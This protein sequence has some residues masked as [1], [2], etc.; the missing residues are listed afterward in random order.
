MPNN[1][2]LSFV[3]PTYGR[4]SLEEACRSIFDY[5][6]ED[7]KA[8]YSIIIG[9]DSEGYGEVDFVTALIVHRI[10]RGGRC[11]I[12]RTKV[13]NI[14][15]LKQKIYQEA[16]LSLTITQTVVDQ[17]KQFIS[18]DVL[19]KGLEIHVDIG[20]NGPTRDTI[21]EI[22]G[23]IKGSGYNV[24]IKP[25]SFGASSVADRYTG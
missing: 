13:P 5:M 8:D 16:A 23:M 10:G 2:D 3:S 15:V 12:T 17:L 22:V 7:N 25:D 24:K 21:K 1:T 19:F 11:F 4:M 9:S 20:H 6:S 14:M 18:E